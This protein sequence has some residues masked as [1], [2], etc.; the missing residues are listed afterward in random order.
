MP[1]FV[2]VHRNFVIGFF[3][4]GNEFYNGTVEN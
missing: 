4:V 1:D 3:M 2:E